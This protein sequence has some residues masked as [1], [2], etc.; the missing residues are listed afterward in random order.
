MRHYR[1]GK[2][3][4]TNHLIA[5]LAMAVLPSIS[6]GNTT[7]TWDGSTT[8]FSGTFA[9]GDNWVGG[10]APPASGPSDIVFG[11]LN[12]HGYQPTMSISYNVSS[13]SFNSSALS[14]SNAN[15]TSITGGAL[16]IRAGGLNDAAS[17]TEMIIAPIVLTAN[18]PWNSSAG[19]FSAT[20]TVNLSTFTLT[21]NTTVAAASLNISGVL[22]G[23]GSIAKTGPGLLAISGGG[24]TG[25]LSLQ[26]GTTQV[27]SGT[28][29]PAGG[30]ADGIDMNSSVFNV[31]GGAKVNASGNYDITIDTGSSVLVTG[32]GSQLNGTH[33]ETYVNGGSSL[34]V[35]GSGS[36]SS[37]TFLFVGFS[38]T[39]TLTVN[40]QG[41]VTAPVTIL[42]NNAGCTGIAS[43]DGAGSTLTA[44][45]FI[46]LGGDGGPGGTGILTITNGGSVITPQASFQSGTSSINV[47]GGTL[48]AGSL[49]STNPGF[50][51]ISLTNPTGGSALNLNGSSGTNV[52]SG[53]ISGTGGLTKSGGSTQILSGANTFTGAVYVQGGAL[54]MSSGAASYYEV[55]SGSLALGGVSLG[56]AAIA[57][58]TGTTVTFTGPTVS[59]GYLEGLGNYNV[60]A[61]TAFIGTTIENGTTITPA[62]NTGL[63]AVTNAG[64]V[65]VPVGDTVGWSG[66]SN[67]G[68]NLNDSGGSTYLSGWTSSGIAQVFGGGNLY[69]TGGTNMVLLGGSRTYVGI[70]GGSGGSIVLTGG[71]TVE[72]NGG[73]LVNYGS[74]YGGTVDVN[75]GGLA[76][77]TGSYSSVVVNPGGTYSPGT[78]GAASPGP[79]SGTS[80]AAI[81]PAASGVTTSGTAI[82]T[83]ASAHFIVNGTDHLTLT[84]AVNT[85]DNPVV[86]TGTGTVTLFPFVSNGLNVSAGVMQLAPAGD[87]F[88]LQPGPITIGTGA[89][90]DVTSDSASIA[91]SS[92]A[93]INAVVQQGF[94]GGKWNGSGI[95]SSTAASDSKHLTAVGVI[96]NNQS[97]TAIYN[98][99]NLF[100]GVLNPSPGNLL[101]AYTYYGDTNLDGKVDGSDY[102]RIDAAYLADKTNP[103]AMTGWFNGDF[104]Y[105]GV[106]NGS[107]YTLIDNAFNRQGAQLT[108]ELATATSQ[109][110]NG[111][112]VPEPGSLTL[113]AIGS[114]GLLR[115]RKQKSVGDYQHP[116]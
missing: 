65:N 45:A 116:H 54:N 112:P 113:L 115:R 89:Q 80:Y 40:T 110:A 94:N 106:V 48:N 66:G 11:S 78:Y 1:S 33:N 64:T 15:G 85:N 69:I 91:G 36:V 109:I 3:R 72:L 50:G 32:A 20:N 76:T 92:L 88:I 62:V 49:G 68:G 14:Y 44:S 34:T 95:V 71:E 84:S 61:V 87:S 82:T 47:N 35:S 77:G 97:G 79:Q 70:S 114:A 99:G 59:G 16:S 24:N 42:G 53:S 43:V 98:A 74:I 30:G 104:N 108:S 4:S 27:T 37:P 60:S 26:G 73:L 107:D 21:A 56:S 41:T 105:D 9:H 111:A 58:A 101:L 29:T 90:L 5:A 12:T 19:S 86:K 51:A 17:N 6:R 103:A 25:T 7:Y 8:S 67:A 22:S 28:L 52:Y 2:N 81:Q 83:N 75:F 55:D 13:F 63:I 96:Q 39:T 10:V 102:S 46:G 93:S 38:G 100:H 31:S 18:Q 57:A 23:S